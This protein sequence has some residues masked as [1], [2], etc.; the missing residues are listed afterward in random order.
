MD[1]NISEDREHCRERILSE[2]Y[3]DIITDI[4]DYIL[5]VL[6]L[7][8]DYCRQV[9]NP[10]YNI[11]YIP[12][13]ARNRY[14]IERFGY[15]S[16][17]N[18]YS[19]ADTTSVNEIGAIRVRNQPALSLR[20]QNVLIGFVDTGI[21]YTHPAFRY[22]NGESRIVGIWDQTIQTGNM[23]D[24][25]DYGSEYTK[26]MIDAALRSDNPLELVPST[27]TNGHGTFIAGVAAGSEDAAN[28]FTGVAPD[29]YIGV[30]KLKE[31]KQ[32]IKDYYLIEDG[33]VAYQE[34][35]VMLGVRYLQDLADRINAPLVICL[36]LQNNLGGHSGESYLA[37]YLQAVTSQLGCSAVSAAGN[38]ANRRRHF[39][40]SF[41]ENEEEMTVEIRVGENVRG[42]AL[43]LWGD[44]PDIYSISIISP[45]GEAVPRESPRLDESTVY[46]FVFE[47]TRIYIDY[48]LSQGYTGAELIFMRFERPTQ[49]IWT[50]RVFTQGV[51]SGN[52]HMWL[53]NLEFLNEN[54]Y[55][56]RPN[57]DITVTDP[58]NSI[59]VITVGAYNHY[60]NSIYLYSGRGFTRTN[61]I[62]PDIVAPGVE[63]YGPLPNNRYGRLSGTSIAAAHTAG[64]VALLMEW[65]LEN[66][67]YVFLL[68]EIIKTYLIRGAVRQ[69]S[70]RTYPSR[71]WGYGKLN[72]AAT[73]DV[74][75]GL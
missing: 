13:S 43:E 64:A 67:S 37:A 74:I 35:D 16:I 69:P 31:A 27:D 12:R 10:S 11:L 59:G 63:I 44:S 14:S 55:F 71:E 42:F 66:E 38:M 62:K 49:G 5:D 65:G 45:S 60:N 61:V 41:T 17:P 48:E 32:D 15:R 47:D 1:N 9:V 25:I 52:F 21:D 3:I 56:L 34:N 50:I 75:A 58:G 20:G 7:G 28:D 33:A 26:E 73:F 30:V 46:D 40:G 4:A 22:S 39:Q 8:E 70:E 68:N 24:G 51:I 18:L 6:D 36:G 23:P 72:I 29:A 2:D 53:P 54:T 57:P 19:L